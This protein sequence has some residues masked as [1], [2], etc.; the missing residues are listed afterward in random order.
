MKLLKLKQIG[1]A[2]LMLVTVYSCIDDVEPTPPKYSAWGFIKS[3]NS[4]YYVTIDGGKVLKVA[5][6]NDAD[7]FKDVEEND[8]LIV[9]FTIEDTPQPRVTY[10]HLINLSSYR[11]VDLADIITLNDVSRDT[12]GDG[13]VQLGSLGLTENYLNMQ[14]VYKKEKGDHTFS[15]CYD[16]TIQE[17]DKAIILM[18]KN[19]FPEEE[20]GSKDTYSNYLSYDI[21]ELSTLGVLN[22]DKEIDFILR[23][24]DDDSQMRDYEVSYTPA[25]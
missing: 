1:V 19:H 20:D 5:P 13:I 15:L 23:I 7:A 25:E 9:D 3:L 18:L 21:S 11:K 8:R 12:I 2:F 14:V 24:N 10:D 4:E 16:E 6:I 22:S 17:E